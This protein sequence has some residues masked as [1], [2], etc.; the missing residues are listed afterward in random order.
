VASGLAVEIAPGAGVRVVDAAGYPL[1]AQGDAVVVRPG[2]LFAGQERRLWVTLAVPYDKAGTYDLGRFSLSYGEG[3]ARRTTTLSEIPQVA[4]V[5]STDQ[6]YGGFDVDA[7]SRSVVVDGYNKMQEEVA[8]EV[9]AGRRDEA[10][11]R[12]RQFKEKTAEMNARLNSAPVAAQ[13]GLTD[14]LE[15]DVSAAFEGPEQERRQN[16]LSKSSS[17]RSLD[18]RRAGSKK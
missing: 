13:L 10:L 18:A 2:S 12:V 11:Y 6:F 8:R 4:C 1:E 5:Q 15:A 17:A 16:E 3:S 9:K 14:K 7:W